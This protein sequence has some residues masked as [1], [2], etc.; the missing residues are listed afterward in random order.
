MVA[1]VIENRAKK[2]FN[3]FDIDQDGSIT[4]HDF[5]LMAK[6]LIDALDIQSSSAQGRGVADSYTKVWEELQRQAD[7]NGNGHVTA[8]EYAAVFGTKDFV[9]VL[10]QASD[11]E[12]KAADTDGD[13]VLS[14]HELR[15]ML[16]AYGVPSSE[17]DNAVQALDQ[18]GDGRISRQEYR[19]AW[20]GYYTDPNV[21]T[22]VNKALGRI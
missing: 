9:K 11:A 6:R 16:E 2:I 22:P 17:I 19:D 21:D 10:D 12:F 18:D 5:D 1:T 14:Q 8:E 15:R 3:N 4:K 20:H 7:T 13:G